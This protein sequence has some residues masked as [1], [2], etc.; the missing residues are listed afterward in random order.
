MSLW[1]ADVA[2]NPGFTAV[3]VLTL[4]LGIGA[5]TAIFSVVH[6][7]LFGHCPTGNPNDWCDCMRRD[8]TR[9]GFTL[10]LSLEGAANLL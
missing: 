7:V 2:Q 5:N 10:S 3:A 6:A 8:V 9:A 4:A 1:C